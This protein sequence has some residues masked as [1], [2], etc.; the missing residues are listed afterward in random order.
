MQAAKKVIYTRLFLTLCLAAAV[1]ASCD[2]KELWPPYSG[3]TDVE[4][5]F[6]W[7][8]APDADPAGMT[9]IFYPVGMGERWRF[10]IAGRDGGMIRLPA[11]NYN[12][13]AYNSDAYSVL[14][15]DDTSFYG[16]TAYTLSRAP[17]MLWCAQETGFEIGCCCCCGD[18]A[19][20]TEAAPAV[21]RLY[22]APMCAEYEINVTDVINLGN[23]RRID[24]SLS[25]LAEGVRLYDEA[26]TFD[27]I[28]LPVRLLR[29]SNTSLRDATS[30]HGNMTPFG[31][32]P[33]PPDCNI[34]TINTTLTNDS[35]VTYAFDVTN[36]IQSAPDP[37][38][39]TINVSGIM[40]PDINP[41][42]TV[43]SGGIEAAVDDWTTVRI[44]LR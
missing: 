42:D 43:G 11:G 29:R 16:I 1:T 25:G 9:L 8:D 19:D 15:R 21:L 5:V 40:I 12:V 33:Q 34:L 38:K 3:Q 14:M 31:D 41:A 22:P 28:T 10:D 4:V 37:K 17:E 2:H 18:M 30:L 26:L 6:D 23:V 20:G 44:D 13:M 32:S 24:A 39:V 7:I 35:A 36:Q 27:T